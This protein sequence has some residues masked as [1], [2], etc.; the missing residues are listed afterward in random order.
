MRET[1]ITVRPRFA[2]SVALA[3][4]DISTSDAVESSALAATV[5]SL[6]A[7]LMRVGGIIVS[8]PQLVVSGWHELPLPEGVPT[9][10]TRWSTGLEDGRASMGAL[11][12]LPFWAHWT[13]EPCSWPT[14][15]TAWIGACRSIWCSRPWATPRWPPWAAI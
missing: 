3:H 5:A 10:C 9:G 2:G 4:M 11:G 12:H 8:E 6:L 15:P 1:L 14:R 13:G 7:P